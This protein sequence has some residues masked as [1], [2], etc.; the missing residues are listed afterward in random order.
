MAHDSI[1]PHSIYRASVSNATRRALWSLCSRHRYKLNISDYRHVPLCTSGAEQ[2]IVLLMGSQDPHLNILVQVTVALNTD[3]EGATSEL[4]E[5][6]EKLKEA[7]TRIAQL[8]AERDG[9]EPPTR[10]VEIP[11]LAVSPPHKRVRYGSS[12]ATTG[13]RE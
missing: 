9:R 8:E 6:H 13:L 5:T 7:Y 3:L 4:D 12:A 1:A 11:Y 2:T 10:H